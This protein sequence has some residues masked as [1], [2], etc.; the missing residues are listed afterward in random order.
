MQPD[1]EKLGR[2][3]K[4]SRTVTI[5]DVDCTESQQLC[6]QFGVQGYPTMKIFKKDGKKKGE[7]YNG[8]REYNGMKR[9]VE[10]NLAGPECSLEDTEGCTKQEKEVLLESAAMSTAD[11]RAK[12]KELE[13]SIAEN[14]K[15]AKELEKEAKE[16]TA[17][18][19]LYKLGGEKPDR[20]VQLVNDADFK[21]HCETRTCVIAFLPHILDGGAAA[22]NKDLKILESMF[23]KAKS[24]GHPVGFMWSQGGDQFEQEEKLS[25]QFGFP[26]VIAISLKKER[27]GV[28][29]GTFD[30]E[31]LQ[32][33]LS[34]MM[35]GRVPLAP[36][37]KG[38]AFSKATAWDGKDGEIPKEE[39]L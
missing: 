20:V 29:R 38:F 14:K 4:Q 37:P 21:E 31:S 15:K 36:L 23:K 16:M 35:T 26:A 7:D 22:R 25:L 9:Y 18:L 8:P 28:H 11:R 3:Y 19:S 6:G 24:D 13:T 5:V 1:W 12:I 27:Y 10:Q 34:S 33:F 30:K 32:G 39:E 2:D 17:K